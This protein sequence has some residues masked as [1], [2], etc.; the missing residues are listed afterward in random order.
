MASSIRNN[1]TNTE[2]DEII[3][4]TSFTSTCSSQHSFLNVIFGRDKDG[5]ETEAEAE[6]VEKDSS[7][8][9]EESEIA[10][11][12]H[13]KH[14]VRSIFLH[15]QYRGANLPFMPVIVYFCS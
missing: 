12:W 2:T 15:V 5:G 10:E 4:C 6:A 9:I 13:E 1:D 3:W 11:P 8:V 7:I 14:E